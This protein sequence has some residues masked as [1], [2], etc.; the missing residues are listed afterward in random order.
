MWTDTGLLISELKCYTLPQ[1]LL[2]IWK[3]NF[4]TCS[5]MSFYFS[6]QLQGDTVTVPC[7]ILYWNFAFKPWVKLFHFTITLVSLTS[8]LWPWVFQGNHTLWITS[9][10][11]HIFTFPRKQLK[12]MFV[13]TVNS[14]CWNVV[15]V[16]ILHFHSCSS[17]R[18]TMKGQRR[19]QPI[20]LHQ[21]L[22][23]SPAFI[24]YS[25]RLQP[26]VAQRRDI[27]CSLSLP[28]QEGRTFEGH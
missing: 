25:T 22:S 6:N 16:G 8:R 17:W 2:N 10:M 12:I 28:T 21:D 27:G 3:I 1:K 9:C 23:L 24:T 15:A 18:R 7:L 5:W 26:Q 13:S 4:T 19:G 11:K 20:F 14:S